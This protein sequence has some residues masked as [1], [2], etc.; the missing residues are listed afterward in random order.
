MLAE[1]SVECGADDPV[2]VVPWSSPD[3]GASSGPHFVDLR[4]NPYDLDQIPEAELHPPLMQALRA[5]NA[6][7]SPVFT[8]KCD[9]WPMDPGELA[10]TRLNLELSAAE[11]PD[12]FVS[13]IDIVWRERSLFVSLPQQQQRLLR[14]VRLLDP[15]DHPGA[16]VEAVIRPAMVELAGRAQEG[17]AVSL[18]VKALGTD[19]PHAYEHWTRALEALVLLLRGKELSLA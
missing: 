11:S 1:W 10:A 9:A 15:L 18:Y 13:Y 16:A 14:L 17:F 2:L 12:G 19:P 3:T 5:L 7:R 4:Q 8:A 6:T